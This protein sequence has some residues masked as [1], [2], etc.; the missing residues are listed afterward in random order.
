MTSE[1][2][3]R[4]NLDLEA[5]QERN[6]LMR[7]HLDRKVNPP[8][9]A[10]DQFLEDKRRAKAI[11]SNLMYF[12][13]LNGGDKDIIKRALMLFADQDESKQNC[14]RVGHA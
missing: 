1:Q 13:D 2:Y 12:V 7:E 3:G 9:S 10:L 11:A 14:L 6:R 5:F 8:L 4:C